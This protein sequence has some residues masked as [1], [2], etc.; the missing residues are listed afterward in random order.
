MAASILGVGAD[1]SVVDREPIIMPT[2][3]EIIQQI[4][5]ALNVYKEHRTRAE[6]DDLSDLQEGIHAEVKARGR[7][8]QCGLISAVSI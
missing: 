7:V 8:P 5:R 2:R 1:S 6:Y 4:D 3:E